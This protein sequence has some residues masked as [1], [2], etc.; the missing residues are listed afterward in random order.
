MTHHLLKGF[1]VFKTL[2]LFSLKSLKA[3]SAITFCALFTRNFYFFSRF[4]MAFNANALIFDF[5]T[6]ASVN[7]A[8]INYIVTVLEASGLR[9]FLDCGQGYSA[10][11]VTEFFANAS[12]RNEMFYQ[13]S[14]GRLA[15][16]RISI[17]LMP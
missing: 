6:I 10:E 14:G 17:L 8:N 4:S 15:A 13:T 9:K 3:I 7:N 2:I 1:Y 11:V 5:E 16:S 12:V